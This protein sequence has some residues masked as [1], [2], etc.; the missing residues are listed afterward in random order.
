MGV[1][2]M[3]RPRDLVLGTGL[4]L[5]VAVGVGV[6]RPWSSSSG[7]CDGDYRSVFVDRAFADGVPARAAAYTP[8]VPRTDDEGRVRAVLAAARAYPGSPVLGRLRWAASH[9][10]VANVIGIGQQADSITAYEP[11]SLSPM[12]D[13]AVVITAPLVNGR[14]DAGDE[15]TSFGVRMGALRASDGTVMW[16]CSHDTSPRATND[17]EETPSPP[18]LMR[19]AT[20]RRFMYTTGIKHPGLTVRDRLTGRTIHTAGFFPAPEVPQVA[21][22]ANTGD[23]T[24]IT[25]GNGVLIAEVENLTL[26]FDLP[27]GS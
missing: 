19:T 23:G 16:T 21:P 6:W 7:P 24:E 1:P 3:P 27:S 8:P 10:I 5:V 12:S 20:T 17:P 4:V 9:R 22:G 25:T 11:I 14:E 15:G 2:G 26:A 13:G 18:P